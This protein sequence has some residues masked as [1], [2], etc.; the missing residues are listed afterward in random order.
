MLPEQPAVGVDIHQRVVERRS[1]G[2]GVSFVDPYH[3]V[4][5]RFTRGLAQLLDL[6]T[7]YR[8]R[9]LHELRVQRPQRRRV[10]RRDKPN[11][12]GVRRDERFR[13]YGELGTAPAG[14]VNET[15]GLLDRGGAIQKNRRR[16]HGGHTE[17][18]SG[19][20]AHERPRFRRPPFRTRSTPTPP[21]YV[22]SRDS[23][24]SGWTPARTSSRGLPR[25]RPACVRL[26][27]A[28]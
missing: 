3:D 24:C 10:P 20:H 1:A 5:A 26:R 27:A 13:K 6:R 16:L 15:A 17:W 2:L 11:P 7:R 21:R 22:R 18:L 14:I 23:R 28:R 25:G 9:V 12:E 4:D 8:D 19:V